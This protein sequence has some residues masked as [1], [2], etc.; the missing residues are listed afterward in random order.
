MSSKGLRELPIDLERRAG[1]PIHK[2][3]YDALRAAMLTGRLR[4]G[5]RL[6]SSRDLGQQ[7]GVA[8]GTVVAVYEQ[9]AGEGYLASRTGSG[10]TVAESLPD[11]WFKGGAA[12]PDPEAP[13]R[14]ARRATSLSRWGKALD[15]SP[16]AVTPR[17]TVRP[18]RAHLPAVDA[19]PA[20][21]WGRIVGKRARRDEKLLLSDGDARGHGPLREI[22]GEHLRVSR[23][24]A[25]H[26]DQIVILPSVQQAI[27]IAARLTVDPGDEIW[28]ED[29][30]YTGARAVLEAAGASLVPVPVDAHGIDVAAGA[31]LAPDARMAYVTPG[32]QAPLGVTLAIDRRLALLGWAKD[33]RALIIED[34]Y[35]SEY[36][37]EGRPVPALQGL[38]RAGVVLHTGTFSKTLLPSLRLAYAVV[39]E[40]LVDSFVAAKSIL[41]RY[42]PPLLQAALADFIEGG[43]FGRHLRRMREIYAERRAALLAAIEADLA[44]TLTVVGASAGLDVAVRL[45][46]GVDDRAVAGDLAAAGVEALAL[47]RHALRRRD[48]NGLLLGFAAFSPARIRKSM[49]AAAAVIRAARPARSGSR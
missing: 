43:H 38:D 20:E 9:L 36:R 7:L 22:L 19:F 15:A 32:H 25:C 26:A 34:D 2:A 49:A 17:T 6:P 10:T 39:P 27:D 30:G 21:D 33:Q 11:R 29:P 12:P 45:P 37:Y 8:R 48:V 46:K 3:L 14:P 35:D 47:S 31:R 4:P 5:A 40:G 1:V 44:D 13:P 41:D 42:T 18:F 24:V 28:M 16:F 23:G